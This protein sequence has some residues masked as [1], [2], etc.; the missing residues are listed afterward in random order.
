MIDNN[1]RGFKKIPTIITSRTCR[2]E[3]L[4]SAVYY[5]TVC[6]AVHGPLVSVG[7]NVA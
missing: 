7:S 2:I 6:M 1:S 3:S 4:L 5:Y